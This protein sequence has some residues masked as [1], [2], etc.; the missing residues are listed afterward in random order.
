MIYKIFISAILLMGLFVNS[1]YS[2]NNPKGFDDFKNPK[3]DWFEA[4]DAKLNPDNERELL[5]VEG[6]GV[7]VNGT[8][9]VTKHLFTKQPHGDIILELEFMLSKGSNS[10]VYLQ[11]RYEV[12]VFDSSGKEKVGSGDCGGIYERWDEK[13]EG[14]KG[15]D[16]IP[17]LINACKNPGEWQTYYIHFKA[18]RFNKKGEKKRNARFKKVVLNGEVVHKNVEATGPT[19]SSLDN[20]EE[21]TGLLM[22][23][24]DHGPVAYRNIRIR[25][26]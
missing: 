12:Q 9:G 24:G 6:E 11:G 18:P 21:P 2:Q 10:G 13:R 16:G 1:G 5:A 3:G 7:F 4:G 20:L 8:K 22:L 17:P 19:R 25:K 14:K 15:Y 23:Q 26:R